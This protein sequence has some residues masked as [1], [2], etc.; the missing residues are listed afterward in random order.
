[1]EQRFP[2]AIE[3]PWQ[4]EAELGNMVERSERGREPLKKR[5]R[6]MLVKM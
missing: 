1:V 5:K 2:Q 4:Q 3:P 6:E